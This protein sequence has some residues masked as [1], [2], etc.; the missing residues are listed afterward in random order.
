MLF[1]GVFL[2]VLLSTTGVQAQKK[3]APKKQT[4]TNVETKTENKAEDKTTNKDSIVLKNSLK[5]L[6]RVGEQSVKLR[7]ALEKS[8]GWKA[9]NEYGFRVE[10]YTLVRDTTWLARP[11]LTVLSDPYKARPVAEWETL[12]KQDDYAA[13]MAQTLY[14]KEM[15]VDMSDNNPLTQIVTESQ[16][17]EQRYT[18]SM[19]ASDMSFEAAKMAAWGFED[20]NVKKNER[21]LYRIIPL[22]PLNQVKIDSAFVVVRMDEY[23]PLPAP[24]KPDILFSDS[25]ATLGYSY[26]LLKDTYLAFHVERSTDGGKT[27]VQITKTPV[28]GMNEKK[29]QDSYRFYFSDKLSDNTTEYTYRIKGVT[30]FSDIGPVSPSVKGKGISRITAHFIHY[31]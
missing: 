6:T 27:F 16:D 29:T 10:R 8:L 5:L 31:Q 25:L 1:V 30:S 11:E 28:T 15:Q 2:M 21:Y 9:C 19:L 3:T 23:K 20:V 24:G 18:L 26:F 14:G 7:W 4:S 13:I 17:L 22:A 12:A